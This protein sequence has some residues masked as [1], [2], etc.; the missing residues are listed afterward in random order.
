M[1]MIG[2]APNGKR[3]LWRLDQKITI[4]RYMTKNVARA[5]NL[6]ARTGVAQGNARRWKEKIDGLTSHDVRCSVGMKLTTQG[7]NIEAS[8]KT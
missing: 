4:D 7:H 2:W 5:V 6:R 1:V 8:L 3:E